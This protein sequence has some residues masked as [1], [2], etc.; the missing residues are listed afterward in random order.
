MATGS[1][2]DPRCAALAW[3]LLL[4]LACGHTD[5]FSSPPY[6]TD[7]PFDPTPP[8]RLTLNT[9]A[10]RGA[11]WLPD[12]SGILYSAQQL[13]RPDAD[14]CLAELPASGGTQRRLVC[15]LSR[16]GRDTANAIESPA[17]STEGRLAFVKAS[18][19]IHGRDPRSEALALAPTLDPSTAV[20]VQRIPY[21]VPGEPQVSGVAH[22]RWVG[23]DRLVYVAGLAVRREP[24]RTCE[25]DTIATGLWVA[26]LDVSAP[27]MPPAAVPGT[28]FASGVSPGASEDEIYY[29][30]GGDTRVF[31]RVLS[32]GDV[33]VAHDFGPAGI[34]RDVD[35]AGGRLTAIVGGRVA[36]SVDPTLGPTQWD[37]GGMVHVVE[38]S[39]G[40]DVV[41]PG[42]GLFRRPALSPAGD[43]IVAEGYP[44]RTAQVIDPATQQETTVTTVGRAGDLYLFDTP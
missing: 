33:S 38:L 24:C 44:V 10:D 17:V 11:S 19:L 25:T 32:S 31:R 27:G 22:L 37:S 26:L 43:R 28:D 2:K 30:L 5:P 13:G 29:T 35:V 20:E 9:A 21:T 40:T 41:L 15:D 39:S 16:L 12:G 8:V 3:G 18:S 14:V 7:L 1:P 6:G 34:A 36:F 4:V 42:P 23:R